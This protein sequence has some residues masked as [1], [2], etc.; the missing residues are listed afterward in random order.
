MAQAL[1]AFGSHRPCPGEVI[2]WTRPRT[3]LLHPVV[4]NHGEV[5]EDQVVHGSDTVAG[6]TSKCSGRSLTDRTF[7][8]EHCAAELLERL[9]MIDIF[10]VRGTCFSCPGFCN[11]STSSRED[12]RQPLCIEIQVGVE[13]I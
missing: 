7:F 12:F 3:V 6:R 1:F 11:C 5:L 9:R 8:V 2:P 10:L 13:P 4:K